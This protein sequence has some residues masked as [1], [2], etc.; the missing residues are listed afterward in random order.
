MSINFNSLRIGLVVDVAVACLAALCLLTSKLSWRGF[1]FG[2]ALS[3]ASFFNVS[4]LLSSTARPSDS[5]AT[6][7]TAAL[8]L[9]MCTTASVSRGNLRAC[10][11]LAQA[12]SAAFNLLLLPL[13][14][15]T[16]S[17]LTHLFIAWQL[18]DARVKAL[19]LGCLYDMLELRGFALVMLGKQR[20][21][22]LDDI[23]SPM[24]ED[25]LPLPSNLSH[26][27]D[28]HG[29]SVAGVL[30]SEWTT[31]TFIL[32][33]S[34]L[35]QLVVHARR[36]VF[37]ALLDAVSRSGKDQS[38]LEPGALFVVWQLLALTEPIQEYFTKIKK[39]LSR[40]RQARLYGKMLSVYAASRDPPCGFWQI[41]RS[42]E[43]LVSGIS[44]ALFIVSTSLAEALNAWVAARKI[45]WHALV[46]AAIALV[47]ALLSRVVGRQIK[48]LRKRDLV[49]R[50]PNFRESFSDMLSNIRTIKSYAWED[51]FRGVLWPSLDQGEYTPPMVW[52][53]L[54]FGL[55][56]LGSATAE[57]SAA[58]AI[59]SYINVAEAITYTD[60]ALLTE[61]IQSLTTCTTT[62]VTMGKAIED[63]RKKLRFLQ[64]FIDHESAKYIERAPTAG[65]TAVDLD[66]SIFSWGD[67]SYS[68]APIT[69][70]IKAGDFVTVV[71]RIGSGKTSFLSAICGEM[72]LTGGRGCV[73]GRIG[74]V[75]QKPWIMNDTFRENVL[76]GADFD[77]AYFWRVVD[78]CALAA[79][80]RLFPNGD[81][82]MIGTNGVNLSGGQKVR[83]ALAS[84][85]LY[86]RADIYV[87]D[88]LLAAVDA[89][90]ERHIVERVLAADGIIG[91]KTRILVTHAEHLVPLSDTVI[92][93]A[94]GCMSVVRQTPLALNSILNKPVDYKEGVPSSDSESP[95]EQAVE[96]DIYSKLPAVS[97]C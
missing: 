35:I 46:P 56:L 34:T 80:V 93:F 67:N 50:P 91:Q 32:A 52:R 9:F 42:V 61:S 85:A 44:H 12:F 36:L 43:G 4:L 21:F 22:T 63:V 64:R 90:V 7:V 3:A 39:S 75:Q 66:E 92:A 11:H 25:K 5:F 28:E 51:A 38:M 31:M 15:A 83:L 48:R 49:G 73:Y 19:A 84:R 69:L 88:D 24:P 86:L 23:C 30:I 72:P 95:K 47:H 29:F 59:T 45:G 16:A 57:I 97:L 87:L 10:L 17:A 65:G 37:I 71:G 60:V 41:E 14:V 77:E 13:P 8:A 94:D 1:S 96:A 55:H 62:V 6:S 70:Q 53:A 26:E 78:A 27:N 81:L 33:V 40:R 68:L 2:R 20:P 74:Y 58:L 79:D 54:Q 89:H 76:M 18:L 82:T